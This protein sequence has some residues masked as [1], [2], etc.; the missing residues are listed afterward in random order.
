M[1]TVLRLDIGYQFR[2]QSKELHHE[3]NVGVCNVTNHFNPFMLY[4]DSKTEQWTQIALLTIM[5]T[6]SYSVSF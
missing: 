4:F 1:P 2:F 3:F 5:P 6:F